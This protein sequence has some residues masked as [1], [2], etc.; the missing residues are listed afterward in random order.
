MWQCLL[1]L[2]SRLHLSF[3]PISGAPSGWIFGAI[4]LIG[5]TNF[6]DFTHLEPC[7]HLAGGCS[8]NLHSLLKLYFWSVLTLVG[9]ISLSRCLLLYLWCW[10][11]NQQ[12]ILRTF[13]METV[14]C[15]ENFFSKPEDQ[16]A[17]HWIPDSGDNSLQAFSTRK[18]FCISLSD[19]IVFAF[20]WKS[21]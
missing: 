21:L 6:S 5:S 9:I 19:F 16:T 12:C 1:K 7:F 2:K 10:A 15:Y 8:F 4:W 20:T 14:A 17:K 13:S 18:L 3:R 11:G